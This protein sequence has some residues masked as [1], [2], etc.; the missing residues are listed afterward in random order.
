MT[1]QHSG[2]AGG[3]ADARMNPNPV[4]PAEAKAVWH[5]LGRP[6]SREVAEWFK[7]AGRPVRHQTVSNWKREGWPGV[8]DTDFV[9]AVGA[10]MANVAWVAALS[11]DAP[12]TKTAVH[13]SNAEAM[14]AP[15][16]CE[17]SHHGANAELAEHALRI[18]IVG[19]KSVW[20]SILYMALIVPDAA[21]AS[22]KDVCRLL[23]LGPPE[24]IAKLMTAASA[25]I[26]TAV[27]GLRQ[28]G[29]LRVEEAAA[30]PG[31]TRTRS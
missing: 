24:R 21:A 16:T 2:H 9:K 31:L 7:A 5:V 3:A 30:V 13:E 28:L 4:M 14:D 10:A 11:S 17:P 8:S 19:A 20:E 27:E 26:I 12:R 18:A 15:K 6:G 29:V 22:D 23:Q 25:T 1:T